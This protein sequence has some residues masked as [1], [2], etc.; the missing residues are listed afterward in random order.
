[1]HDQKALHVLQFAVTTEV[2]SK[3]TPGLQASALDATASNMHRLMT[4]PNSPSTLAHV[5]KCTAHA[6]HHIH[7]A[8]V[9]DSFGLQDLPA[10]N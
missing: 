5:V 7:E 2:R 3:Q 9:L 8:K 6:N 10:G 1:M 4:E